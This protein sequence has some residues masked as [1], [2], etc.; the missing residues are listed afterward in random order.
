MIFPM[1]FMRKKYWF[2]FLGL[3][4]LVSASNVSGRFIDSENNIL[5][6]QRD[7]VGVPKKYELG[8]ETPLDLDIDKLRVCRGIQL[9]ILRNRDIV[10]VKVSW[11]P[12]NIKDPII[13]VRSFQPISTNEQFLKSETVSV[14]KSG[15]SFF[16]DE[17]LPAGSYYYA[18]ALRSQF[19]SGE[20][21]LYAN[22]NYTVFPLNVASEK[23]SISGRYSNA[24]SQV[25]SIQARM[26]NETD[27]WI[28]WDKVANED[29]IYVVYRS[30]HPLDKPS[31]LNSNNII[32]LLPSQDNFFTDENLPEFG[33]YYYAVTTRSKSGAEDK[34]LVANESYT[35]EPVL[36][37]SAYTPIVS[38]L[39][40]EANGKQIKLTWSK[41]KTQGQNFTNY[42]L[43]R[44]TSPIAVSSDLDNALEIARLQMDVT[45]YT[46]TVTNEGD[47]YY[48]LVSIDKKGQ[49]SG[50][51]TKGQNSLMLPIK[52]KEETTKVVSNEKSEQEKPNE[53]F[54]FSDFYAKE[55]NERI[56]LF[57][58]SNILQ[59]SIN[60][61]EEVPLAYV[62]RFY[63]RPKT[64]Q[65]IRLG[66][67]VGKIPPQQGFV[68]DRP[69]QGGL[70]YY[71]IFLQTG[72]QMLPDNFVQD[73]NLIGPI[74]FAGIQQ[75]DAPLEISQPVDT[76]QEQKDFE[77]EVE[78]EVQ[79]R[80]QAEKEAQEERD[81]L[82]EEQR[83]KEAELAKAA[84]DN[85]EAQAQKKQEEQD[86]L[87]AEIEKEVQRQ[88]ALR[89][90]KEKNKPTVQ[91]ELPQK[92]QQTENVPPQAK[93]NYQTPEPQ[94]QSYQAA[95]PQ[96]KTDNL[97][98]VTAIVQR[99]YLKG[100]YETAVN[101]L[102]P[103]LNDENLSVQAMA[104]FY[105][106]LS[107]YRLSRFNEALPFFSD[108]LVKKAYKGKVNFWYQR[109]MEYAR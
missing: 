90:K 24:P 44:S 107:L 20:I 61:E 91:K 6:D 65:D 31:L 80:L 32:A 88:L 67:L 14:L 50:K 77:A 25:T 40:G 72:R 46:D 103:F 43:F 18:L 38:D 37:G 59:Q 89:E 87:K 101:N 15:T 68:S 106:G 100:H 52:T 95:K 109:A 36:Y 81:R 98:N 11:I 41:P 74:A 54:P 64:L 47:Y 34:N 30:N 69:L 96:Q 63:K 19:K 85:K 51:I 2:I 49:Q 33:A 7:A 86:K 75:N 28:H 55:E 76:K 99:T 13:L 35:K 84:Q 16:I 27:A 93:Q 66:N 79:R 48:A 29:V 97:K 8:A 3:M 45:S 62:Y 57:W 26:L 10:N 23:N 58:K 108:A 104:K 83:K 78:K 9:E 102:K 92:V 1:D 105:S 71:A 42:K 4:F 21:K 73:K 70:Y 12:P 5:K 17:N 94:Q 39:R 82:A 53:N 22:E 56:V 60:I